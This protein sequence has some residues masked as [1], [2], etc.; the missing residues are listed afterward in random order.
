VA[1][2][3]VVLRLRD[4]VKT[5]PGVVALRGV[6]F[7]VLAG[8][9]HALVGENGAGKSTLMAVAAGST[10]PDSGTVEIGGLPLETASPSVAQ[11]LGLGMVYQHLSILE[12]L[13]VAENLVL[14]MPKASRPGM[15]KAAAWTREQLARVGAEL[16]PA[17]RISDLSTA[18]R[19]LVEIAKALA[20]EAKILILDEP[21]ESLTSAESERLFENLHAIR[22]S[23]T[24]VV[25]ISHRLPEVKRV[26]DRVTVL[27]DGETRGTSDATNMSEA[28]ILR[29]VIGRPV[30][31]AFPARHARGHADA[32]LVDVEGLSG[33]G[34]HAVS[35]SVRPGEIVGLAG[36]EGNGQRAFL[37]ALAGIVPAHGRLHIAG[38]AVKL[39]RPSRMRDAGVI[40]LPG[41]RHREGVM[42]ALSVRENVSLLALSGTAQA[43]FVRRGRERPM[44][45]AQI[46][47]LGVKTPS[48]DTAVGS[49]SGGNQQKVL[50]ARALLGEPRLL[51]AD[52]PTRGVDVGA[53]IELYRVLREAADSGRA[54]IVLSSDAVELQGL[55]DRVLVFSR[56]R[57]VRELEG[58]EIDEENIT[59][60]ALTSETVHHGALWSRARRLQRLRRFSSGDYLPSAVLASLIVLVGIVAQVEN[61]RFLSSYNVQSTLLLAS[62]L[63]FVSLGQAV[64]VMT[65]NIDLSVGPLMGLTVV[66]TS[67]FWTTG[68][69]TGELILGVAAVIGTAAAV[70]TVIGLLVRAARVPS[71]V[72]SLSAYII[73]Q[74]IALLLRPQ[75]A[76]LLR[77]S[78]TAV[79]NADV[80]WMPVALIVAITATLIA[81]L[82]LRRSRAGLQ[83]RAVG[84]DETRAYRLGA[85]VNF[86]HILAFVLCALC[87]AAA[88]VMLAGQSGI[89]DADP[90]LSV[91]Y[92]LTSITA[93]VLGGASIFGGRGSF[94]GALLGA[95]LLTEVVAAVPFLQIPASWNYWMPGILILVGAGIFSRARGGPAGRFATGASG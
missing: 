95:I 52:E 48:Q 2:A 71:V 79:I 60:A 7:E 17:D 59:G 25:Y 94:I 41:D 32:S 24:A 54:V 74:G 89:G 68:Q 3:A 82:A 91:N 13:T 76:G 85:Q 5:F 58:D 75:P 55:C 38:R 34:F 51:L 33:P 84:S 45:A 47:R 83:L 26:A 92:T 72:A 27:R 44:V 67:F 20:M 43:G 46:E 88:G 57:V 40:H 1:S 64:I 39:G 87:A 73:I 30:S 28:D 35:L 49:L 36:V 29:L 16:D 37:R 10:V 42:L 61:G 86:T 66:V 63:A 93:V 8:E 77:P 78:I 22:D 21:T 14:A 4:V 50:F 81:E 56:G 12:D 6:T 19:Q 80:G 90:T 23:G 65:G 11:A 62:A 9:V 53:R 69:G 18:H 15:S 31:E 70:G